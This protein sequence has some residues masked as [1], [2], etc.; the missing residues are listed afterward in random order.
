[1]EG[2]VVTYEKPINLSGGGTMT[3]DSNLNFCFVFSPNT[4]Y[5]GLSVWQMKACDNSGACGTSTASIT[6][7]PVNDPPVAMDDEAEVLGAISTVLDALSNDLV[8]ADPYQ[9]FYD[10]FMERDSVD[11]LQLIR[12]KS[13]NGSATMIDNKIQ[14]TPKF[15][16]QG[17]DS[18]QYWIQDKGGLK[19]SATVHIEVGPAKFR[20]F[21]AVSPNGDELNDYWRING[22]DQDP[23]NTVKIFDRYNNLVFET[24][25]YDNEKNHWYGQANNGLVKG[26][27]PEG[28][29][30]YTIEIDLT[31]DDQGRRIFS[32]FI[33][34]KRN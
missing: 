10:I 23:D 18:V 16:F 11:E 14:Y 15:E 21:Q 12:V 9:E 13:F 20:A 29:Y 28:T 25:S 22:I 1:V 30:Y 17:R 26:T 34:L 24:S 3:S 4:N 32:G 7:L 19:D 8:I 6:V 2:D 27:L 33:V 31:E 5:N